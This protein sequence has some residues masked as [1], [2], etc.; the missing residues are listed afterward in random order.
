[1]NQRLWIAVIVAAVVATAISFAA[2]RYCCRPVTPNLHDAGNLK[3]ELGLDAAQTEQITKL[4]AELNQTLAGCCKKHCA[5]RFDLS[6]KL[7]KAETDR[8]A[9]QAC[10]DR[11][12]AAQTESEQ[13]TLAI[14]LRIRELLTPAQREKYAQ[15]LN[16]QLCTPATMEL[17]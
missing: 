1:M 9:M 14:V 6:Q 7:S 13:A 8:A 3:T 11:M 12:C 4:E 15:L 5:A 10:V 17:H 2:A 16:R